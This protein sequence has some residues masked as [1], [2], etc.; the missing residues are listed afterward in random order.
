MILDPCESRRHPSGESREAAGEADGLITCISLRIPWATPAPAEGR[1][2]ELSV[3][4]APAIQRS[5]PGARNVTHRWYAMQ[6]TATESAA[7]CTRDV[8]S[9]VTERAS[10]QPVTPGR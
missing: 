1:D 9:A 7:I 8:C 3:T 2:G 5:R 10:G 6:E 4:D